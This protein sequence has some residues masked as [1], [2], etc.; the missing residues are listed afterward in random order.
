MKLSHFL[1]Y[2]ATN[3]DDSPLYVF[4]SHF[5]DDDVSKALLGE[6]APP[7]YFRD[8]LF[9][10]CGERK[11]PPY[12]W[13]LLG[14][15]RSGTNVHIDPLAT[16][17][18]NTV[19]SGA[20]L[21]VIFPPRATRKMVKGRH[22][23]AKGGDD[24]PINYFA[25]ILP[26]VK[27]ECAQA[28]IEV[29]E[30]VQR[31]GETLY[32]P[33]GWWHAVLN[34]EDSVAVTQNFCSHSNFD[35]VWCETRHGRKKMAVR[36]LAQLDEHY[37]E[38]AAR[39][40]FLNE[41]DGFTMYRHLTPEQRKARDA[42]KKEKEKTAKERKAAAKAKAAATKKSTGA[43]AAPAGAGAGAGAAAGSGAAAAAATAEPVA[44]SKEESKKRK[45]E[46][47]DR[48]KRKGLGG[49]GHYGYVDGKKPPKA[50]GY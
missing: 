29:Y 48:G 36:W 21:W 46:E 5:D 15:K 35:G 10:L 23:I 20:K 40:R 31:P 43:G 9:R 8:D 25:E 34:L 14:P 19:V 37:P 26:A 11:R 17:A 3:D 50:G 6:F 44:L 13:W 38:L 39:A 45:R 41:R 49:G 7:C 42:E 12:R 32:V 30:F 33:A 18:W 27:R 28:G 4:D 24:E 47:R 2:Q 22:H 16:S 1:K